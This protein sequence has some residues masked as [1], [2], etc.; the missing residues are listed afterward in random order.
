M[1]THPIFES[2]FDCLTD[3]SRTIKLS[4]PLLLPTSLRR[5]STSPKV[6]FEPNSTDTSERNSLRM[7]TP[8]L[9]SESPPS[10][11]KSSSSPLEPRTFWVTRPSEFENYRFGPEA[12]PDQG[13]R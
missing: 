3:L 1:G 2:D 11:L 7:A 10:E 8:A 4:W 13:R 12:I 9:K 5:E 6:S